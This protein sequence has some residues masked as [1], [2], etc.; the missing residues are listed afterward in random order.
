MLNKLKS[1]TNPSSKTK[2]VEPISVPDQ[3]QEQHY[4]LTSQRAWLNTNETA[5]YIGVSHLLCAK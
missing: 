1:S 3:I 4:Y 5:T 2:I